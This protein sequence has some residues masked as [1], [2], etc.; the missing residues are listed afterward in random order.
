M[1]L[2]CSALLVVDNVFFFG[3]CFD[4]AFRCFFFSFLTEKGQKGNLF[5]LRNLN[6]E[7]SIRI[8]AT[9]EF[10]L[11]LVFFFQTCLCPCSLRLNEKEKK[12]REQWPNRVKDTFFRERI[13]VILILIFVFL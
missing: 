1:L 11:N 4:A 6:N 5:T 2:L 9:K 8:L 13:N 10:Q 7:R 12:M 3:V